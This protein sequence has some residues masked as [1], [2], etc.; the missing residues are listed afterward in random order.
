M[1]EVI[2]VNDV[3]SPEVLA[4]YNR[5]SITRPIVNEIY[6]IRDIIKA[7]ATK[8]TGLLLNEVKNP[9]VEVDHP[10][11]GKKIKMEPNFNINRFT[12][13]YGN[14]LTK[15]SILEKTTQKI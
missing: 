8:E 12:D 4:F 5:F 6:T 9:L 2:Y 15:D 1:K 14:K 10:I 7:S 11:L 13:L 3:Y